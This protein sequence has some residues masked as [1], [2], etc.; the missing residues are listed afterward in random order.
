ML[1]VILALQ[2]CSPVASL[3]P[4]APCDDSIVRAADVPPA[5]TSRGITDA[6][7]SGDTWFLPPA[8]GNFAQDVR[9]FDGQYFLKL[10]VW[11]LAPVAPVITIRWVGTGQAQGSASSSP[12]TEGLP[13]PL[14][15]TLYF[16]QPGCWDVTAQGATGKAHV[17]ISF[18]E[19]ARQRK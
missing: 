18:D 2:A 17:R 1:T 11:S 12:T 8:Q 7:G 19:S 4:A 14:P 10:G 5:L 6:V 3:Q 13:G 9:W 16:P 15:T